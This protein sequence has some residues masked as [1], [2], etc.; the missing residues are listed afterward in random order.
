MLKLF[1]QR[2]GL[3]SPRFYSRQVERVGQCTSTPGLAIT[4]LYHAILLS[5]A[6]PVH[7]GHVQLQLQLQLQLQTTALPRSLFALH[8]SRLAT[9]LARQRRV[10]IGAR[11][12]HLHSRG[13]RLARAANR[14]W[15]CPP[16]PIAT[17]TAACA[18]TALRKIWARLASSLPLER[19]VREKVDLGSRSSGC[20]NL[21]GRFL[22]LTLRLLTLRRLTLRR[23]LLGLNKVRSSL[24]SSV[25]S[26]HTIARVKA[27]QMEIRV[28]ACVSEA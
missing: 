6:I 2:H 19:L 26:T 7:V 10:E 24:A 23:C 17:A 15:S 1:K 28:G 25:V 20:G 13:C 8:R 27:G 4:L 14:P 21:G 22:I 9:P 12:H 16:R 3:P 5:H 11:H 18:A